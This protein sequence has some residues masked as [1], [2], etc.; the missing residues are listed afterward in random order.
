MRSEASP[1]ESIRSAVAT[2]RT[3]VKKLLRNCA[4]SLIEKTGEGLDYRARILS[5]S[6]WA[7]LDLKKELEIFADGKELDVVV[8][9][10]DLDAAAGAAGIEGYG[11]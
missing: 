7:R 3:R 8:E 10:E 4:L 2:T 9:A 5:I 1:S 6:A 11:L